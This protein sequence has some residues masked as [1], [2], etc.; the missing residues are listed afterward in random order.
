MNKFLIPGRE[1]YKQSE[2]NGLNGPKRTI[3]W[4]PGEYTI[5]FYGKLNIV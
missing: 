5:L 1:S 2:N 4:C 3:A